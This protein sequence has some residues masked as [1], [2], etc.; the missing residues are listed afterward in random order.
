MRNE[1]N[2]VADRVNVGLGSLW[3][4][5][6]SVVVVVVWALSG[7]GFHFS[8]SGSSSSIPGRQS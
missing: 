4:L 8:D 6:L 2:R 3:A 7:P 1:F 5:L